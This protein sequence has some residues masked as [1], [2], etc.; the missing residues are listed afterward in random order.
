M[1]LEAINSINR[2][3]NDTK[4][5]L[6]LLETTGDFDSIIYKFSKDEMT[7][8]LEHLNKVRENILSAQAKE[9]VS[10]RMYGESVEC[11]KISNR[12]LISVLN[13]F[14][15]MLD[16][17]ATVVE[18][19]TKNKGKF[20]EAAKQIAD[21][22]VCGTFAGSFGVILEKDCGQLEVADKSTKT[23]QIIE[24]LFDVLE[25]SS[26]GDHLISHI[27]PY[28]QRTIAHYRT[29]L[30]SLKDNSV[31][32]EMKWIDES[33]DVRN[34]NINYTKTEDIIYTLDSIQ[35]IINIEKQITGIL[36]GINIRKNTFELNNCDGIIKGTSKMET[37]ISMTHRIGEEIKANVIESVVTSSDYVTKTTWYLIDIC[38]NGQNTES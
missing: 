3:I 5:Q 23:N 37:L 2:K 12:I 11:G 13:G 30:K 4:K 8:R 33:A 31:N 7:R 20:K 21:F 26:D 24:N 6:E 17:I 38:E 36:T 25:N 34:L 10:I 16:S 19:S 32:I 15:S 14:Q 9:T 18:G 29:W 22:N 35:N 28:G 27:S 1:S